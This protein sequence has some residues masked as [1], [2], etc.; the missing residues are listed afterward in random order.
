MAKDKVILVTTVYGVD[1]LV[2][3]ELWLQLNQCRAFKH[4]GWGSDKVFTE[5]FDTSLET[6][7]LDSSKLEAPEI[8]K[9]DIEDIMDENN[10]LTRLVSKLEDDLKILKPTLSTSTDMEPF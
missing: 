6:T 1:L 2:H 8:N 5:T 7:F 10:R 4:D 9:L 3:P